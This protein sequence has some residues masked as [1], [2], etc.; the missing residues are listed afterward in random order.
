MERADIA[1][2]YGKLKTN[3]GAAFTRS[4]PGDVIEDWYLELRQFP[5]RNAQQA[6]RDWIR[7][8]PDRYPNLPQLRN[9]I[10]AIAQ[11]AQT[12]PDVPQLSPG[13]RAARK[14]QGAAALE[15]MQARFKSSSPYEG[16]SPD[17]HARA[18]H[19]LRNVDGPQ[20][21]RAAREILTEHCE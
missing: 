21:H 7:E 9:R 10:R 3:Y 16:A 18:F 17:Q 19:A 12:V 5:V 6:V 15:R 20:A 1:A 14:K 8:N 11:P 13:E 4:F 2:M